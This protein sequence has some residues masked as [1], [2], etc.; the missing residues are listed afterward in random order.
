MMLVIAAELENEVYVMDIK[1][2]FFSAYVEDK[3]KM[4]PEYERRN[5]AGVPLLIKIKKTPTDFAKAKITSFVR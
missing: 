3:V 2:A 1:T 5:T 4:S